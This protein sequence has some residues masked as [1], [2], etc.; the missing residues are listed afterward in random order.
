M[1]PKPCV[2]LGFC[3]TQHGQLKSLSQKL[4]SVS[5]LSSAGPT[6]RPLAKEQKIKTIIIVIIVMIIIMIIIHIYISKQ[7]EPKPLQGSI[8]LSESN[9]SG[10]ENLEAHTETTS[11]TLLARENMCHPEQKSQDPRRCTCKPAISCAH[12]S[13]DLE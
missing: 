11:K 9:T 10:A 12:S 7:L 8:P 3:S 1:S 13:A 4:A 2:V 5:P 6:Q